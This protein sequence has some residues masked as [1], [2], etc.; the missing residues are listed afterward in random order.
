MTTL[1]NSIINKLS[2]QSS[3]TSVLIFNSEQAIKQQK[4][5]KSI[6]IVYQ[7]PEN[8]LIVVAAFLQNINLNIFT[9]QELV[10]L[11][12]YNYDS[13]QATK[14]VANIH[15]Y[16]HNIPLYDLDNTIINANDLSTSSIRNNFKELQGINKNLSIDYFLNYLI[17][18][19]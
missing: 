10:H 17:S 19:L 6:L 1:I 16:D 3:K 12:G 14:I 5:L 4:K 7:I 11:L 8:S 18:Q 2:A 15:N 13:I 9:E